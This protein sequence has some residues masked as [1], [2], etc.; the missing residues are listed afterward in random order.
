M[1]R[2]A[3]RATHSHPQASRAASA[4]GAAGGGLL[5]SLAQGAAAVLGT[6]LGPLEREGA[7]DKSAAVIS[8]GCLRFMT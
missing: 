3:S 2:P 6:V 4:A 7:F 8:G 5:A 1:R